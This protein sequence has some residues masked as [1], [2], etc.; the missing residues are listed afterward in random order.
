MSH[1]SFLPIRENS[2]ASSQSQFGPQKW[3]SARSIHPLQ[4][5]IRLIFGP[6]T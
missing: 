1:L 6:L 5:I 3:P 4:G 2:S